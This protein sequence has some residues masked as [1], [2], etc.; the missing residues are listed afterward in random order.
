MLQMRAES[1]LLLKID[2]ERTQYNLLRLRLVLLHQQ[3]EPSML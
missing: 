3:L 1:Q 2:I